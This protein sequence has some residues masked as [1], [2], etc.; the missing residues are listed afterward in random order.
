[1]IK[2]LNDR[3]LHFGCSFALVILL[4]ESFA[5]IAGVTK[6]TADVLYKQCYQVGS[7]WDWKDIAADA[8]G[9]ALGSLV[10]RVII[11]Y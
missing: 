3:A 6:E 5:A 7:G 8:A 2:Y 10:R 11:G 4:G 1:M 9:I